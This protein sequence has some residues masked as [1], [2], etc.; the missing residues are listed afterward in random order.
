M[1]RPRRGEPRGE[2]WHNSFP[3]ARGGALLPRKHGSDQDLDNN[4][5]NLAMTRRPASPSSGRTRWLDRAHGTH[6]VLVAVTVIALS[7]A[8]FEASA[9]TPTGATGAGDPA[10]GATAQ[11]PKAKQPARKHTASPKPT[12]KPAPRT[13]PAAAASAP[14]AGAAAGA[15]PA[16]AASGACQGQT[17]LKLAQCEACDSQ[18]KSGLGLRLCRDKVE[19]TYCVK[20]TFK[21]DP[22]CLPK[23]REGPYIN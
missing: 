7:L 6:W 18:G 13:A 22:D 1:R 4:M 12:T 8:G 21:D 16:A 10:Q 3:K 17:G 9:Q 20:R 11:Q 15:A 14:A 5:E 19:L 23:Q 2:L